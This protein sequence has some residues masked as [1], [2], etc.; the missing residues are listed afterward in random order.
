MSLIRPWLE[1]GKYTDTLFETLLDHVGID[2]VLQL[3]EPVACTTVA[4][5]VLDDHD[6]PIPGFDWTDCHPIR[7]DRIDH[8]VAWTGRNADL[9]GRTVAFEFAWMAGQIFVFDFC[10]LTVQ[11]PM[12]RLMVRRLMVDGFRPNR[13]GS[14][15]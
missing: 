14:R 5:R 9:A 13:P 6:Q 3:A 10:W 8:P 15:A 12:N 2:A 11:H 7:G 1:I 4:A